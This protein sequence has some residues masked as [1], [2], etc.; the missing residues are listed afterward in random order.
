MRHWWL[1]VS[2]GHEH[3]APSFVKDGLIWFV[4]AAVSGLG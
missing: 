2:R 1:H 4:R 3:A